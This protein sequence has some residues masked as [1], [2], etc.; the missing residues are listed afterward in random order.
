[1]PAMR[2]PSPGV[3]SLVAALAW[4]FII[5]PTHSLAATYRQDYA[6]LDGGGQSASSVN[7][8]QVISTV[9]LGGGDTVAA[10]T[11]LRPG[12]LGQLND[13]PVPGTDT[14][15][16]PAGLGVKTRV[17]SLLA[18]DIDPEGGPLTLVFVGPADAGG[19]VAL[20]A[21]WVM[22]NP[23]AGQP[24]HDTLRC[25]VADAEGDLAIGLVS[26]AV[27]APGNAPSRNLLAI[28]PLPTGEVRLDFIGLP[29]RW[30][31]VEW[32]SDL[33]ARD[34][35]LLGQ[36]QAGANG[37]FAITD[38]ASDGARFYRTMGE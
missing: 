14:L 38:A 11:H 9:G 30:Y 12:F 1:M 35:Q 7:Y 4:F 33:G 26:V 13:P 3:S 23:P 34:W 6:A 31:R 21:A 15:S 24:A 36:V 17:P 29:G 25:T 8:S 19:L 16:R 2:V 18:N 22:Y 10:G 32:T 27:A 5:Q 28:V 20:D 37:L